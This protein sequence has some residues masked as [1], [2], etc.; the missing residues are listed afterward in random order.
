MLMNT[1]KNA[2]LRVM[3]KALMRKILQCSEM[4]QVY[5]KANTGSKA[6]A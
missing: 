4:A 5:E 6:T 2:T 1:E 3:V